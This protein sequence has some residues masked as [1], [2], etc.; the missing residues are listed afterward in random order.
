MFRFSSALPSAIH[1]VAALAT[2]RAPTATSADTSRVAESAVISPLAA[3]S[4]MR[5]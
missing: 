4:T 3:A 2:S 5:T 1:V